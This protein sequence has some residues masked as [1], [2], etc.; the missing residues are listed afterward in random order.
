MFESINKAFYPSENTDFVVLMFFVHLFAACL[1]VYLFSVINA[2]I[3]WAKPVNVR[4]RSSVRF[5]AE[6][7]LIYFDLKT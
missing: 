5:K 7:S 2:Q 1:H 6:Q 3:D 4:L